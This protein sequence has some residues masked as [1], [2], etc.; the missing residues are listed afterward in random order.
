MNFFTTHP[1]FFLLSL[2]GLAIFSQSCESSQARQEVENTPYQLVW[3]DEFD[4]EGLPDSTKWGYDV[5][6]ACNLPPGCGWGNNE[7]QYYTEKRPKNARVED[8]HL[9]IEVHQEEMGSREYSSARLTSK[10]KGDWL[11][12]RFEIRAKIPR[13]KGIW[14]A[15]WMLSTEDRYNGWPHSGEI[16]IMENVGY[17]PDTIVSSAH[18]LAY[19]HGIGTQKSVRYAVPDAGD[20]FHTYTLEWEKDFYQVLVDDKLTFRFDREGDSFKVWPFDQA[21]HLMLN[22]AYGGNWGGKM[23]VDPSALPARMLIDYVRVYEKVEN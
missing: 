14:S 20:V 2:F 18:T 22:I 19:N 11:Y 3:S 12:G 16:D 6:D 10:G 4:Q 8:G 1:L 9:I 17:D 13:G 21:F 15:I 23:G 5:G 7:L